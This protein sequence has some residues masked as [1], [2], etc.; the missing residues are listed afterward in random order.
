MDLQS[1]HACSHSLFEKSITECPFELC[2]ITL[3]VCQYWNT[4]KSF[5]DLNLKWVGGGRQTPSLLF[6]ILPGLHGNSRLHLENPRL[7]PSQTSLKTGEPEDIC[8]VND[9]C[10]LNYS[11]CTCHCRFCEDLC[12]NEQVRRSTLLCLSFKIRRLVLFTKVWP[13]LRRCSLINLYGA[14]SI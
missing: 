11:L 4:H 8:L 9:E 13:E 6:S 1:F 7:S 5:R 2:K 3:L 10:S 14:F 12:R